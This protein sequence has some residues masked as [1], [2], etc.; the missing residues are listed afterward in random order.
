[1]L[2][3]GA[4]DP[5]PWCCC[6]ILE[7]LI[8][9]HAETCLR[10]A[11]RWP[12][13]AGK[14]YPATRACLP[15]FESREPSGTECCSKAA[16][17]HAAGCCAASTELV[18]SQATAATVLRICCAAAAL[19]WKRLLLKS[20]T[21]SQT[22][23]DATPAGSLQH[24]QACALGCRRSHAVVVLARVSAAASCIISYMYIC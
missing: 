3:G 16:A 17:Q 15:G 19:R 8:A 7:K 13:S 11:F 18:V 14:D 6:A 21:V 5:L 10:C 20:T 9:L 1:M 2:F 4:D 23:S 22:L 12:G 24:V